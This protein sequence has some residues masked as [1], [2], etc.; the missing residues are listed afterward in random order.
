MY[1]L[2]N[3]LLPRV[4]QTY[5]TRPCHSQGTRFSKSNYIFPK[6]QTKLQERSIKTIG[7]RVWATVPQEAKILPF[8]KTFTKHMKN[9][10]L[11]TLPT[12]QSSGNHI[13]PKKAVTN[14]LGQIFL[15]E[16]TNSEFLGFSIDLGQILD[17]ETDSEAE[18]FG[19]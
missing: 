16:S 19:F 1:S 9:L 15:D 5:C 11:K 4:F 17:S 18:F 2:H 6:C 10:Y 7:P 13:P 3:N 12:E 14:E 8:R